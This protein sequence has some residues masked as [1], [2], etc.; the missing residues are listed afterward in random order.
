VDKN[1]QLTW[2]T[3]SEQNNAGFE[4]QRKEESG[5]SQMGYVESKADGGTTTETQSYQYVAEDLSVGT[6]QF[7]LKQVDLDGSSQVHGPISVEIRMQEAIRLT[8]PAPNPVS[9]TATLSFA[10]KEEAQAIVAVY[11]MLGRKAATLFEGTP[12]AGESNRLQFDASSLPSGSYIIRLQAD[13]QTES[14]R[15]TIVR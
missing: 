14:Q 1:V 5:W 8:A 9:S 3:A 6:H 13:G 12:T 7:R 2:K 4:V 15:M 10:V 11:D